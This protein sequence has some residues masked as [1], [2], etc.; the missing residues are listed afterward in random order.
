MILARAE[1]ALSQTI[2]RPVLLSLSQTIESDK[3]SYYHALESAQRSNE[4]TDWIKYFVT[5]TL[6][7]QKQ[8][9]E[10]IELT[11]KKAKFFDHY[12]DKLNERQLKVIKRMME[13]EPKGFEGGM[14]AKKYM[15]ITKTSKATATRDLQALTELKTLINTGGGRNTSYALNI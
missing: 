11:L 5:T 4:I 10:A 15:S 3:R 2:G 8:A 1:K 6:D 13:E 12:R 9:K 14:T 7:A